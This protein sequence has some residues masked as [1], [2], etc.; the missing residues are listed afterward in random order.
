MIM[1]SASRMIMQEELKEFNSQI[2]NPVKMLE[3]MSDR[4]LVQFQ[5][6]DIQNRKE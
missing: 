4:E 1:G 2:Y 3:Q 6:D 5:R